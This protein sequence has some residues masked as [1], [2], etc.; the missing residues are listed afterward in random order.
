MEKEEEKKKSVA[1]SLDIIKFVMDA[2]IHV[3]FDMLTE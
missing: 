1:T 2:A 3:I